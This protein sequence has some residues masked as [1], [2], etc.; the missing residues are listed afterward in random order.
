MW[1]ETKSTVHID[2]TSPANNPNT[3][4]K[5]VPETAR[6]KYDDGTVRKV[7]SLSYRAPENNGYKTAQFLI[8]RAMFDPNAVVL[9]V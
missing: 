9:P 4:L 7:D 1:Y 2:T 8:S 5:T 6:I 3:E